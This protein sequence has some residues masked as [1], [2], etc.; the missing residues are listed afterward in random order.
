VYSDGENEA[1]SDLERFEA[2]A[3]NSFAARPHSSDKPVRYM[4]M[5][6]LALVVLS[7]LYRYVPRTIGFQLL[8]GLASFAGWVVLLMLLV[9]SFIKVSERYVFTESHL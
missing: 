2:G 7:L 3:I 5:F 8:F 9:R 4:L 6:A 1:A